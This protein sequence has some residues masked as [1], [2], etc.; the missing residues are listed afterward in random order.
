MQIQLHLAR[1]IVQVPIEVAA[2][3]R[4]R[5]SRAVAVCSQGREPGSRI[6]SSTNVHKSNCNR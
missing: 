5:I 1:R 6:L 3:L 4:S 2:E